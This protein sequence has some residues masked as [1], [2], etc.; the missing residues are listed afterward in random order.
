MDSEG[1]VNDNHSTPHNS[2]MDRG[3]GLCAG[4]LGCTVLP[5]GWLYVAVALGTVTALVAS[6]FVFPTTEIP[7]VK[8]A[9]IGNSMM[10]YNDFPRFMGTFW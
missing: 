7:H 9:M 3:V 4:A 1:Y 5:L 8:V 6:A 10:Y 2:L